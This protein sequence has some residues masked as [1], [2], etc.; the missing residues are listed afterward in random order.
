MT[1]VAWASGDGRAPAWKAFFDGP[2]LSSRRLML[3]PTELVRRQII[4]EV[5]QEREAVLNPQVKTFNRLES[6]LSAEL[7]PPPV[8]KW[9]KA[10]ELNVLAPELWGA[11]GLPGEPRPAGVIRLAA[12]L[13]DG[14]D[15]LRLAGLSWDE[16]AG[17]APRELT[18]A[19]AEAGRR[20]ERWLGEADDAASRRLKLLEALRSGRRFAAL[21]EVKEIWCHHSQRLS[22]FE[23]EFLKALAVRC[24]VDLRLAA[25]AWLMAENV[26]QNSGWMRLRLLRDLETCPADGL[27]LSWVDEPYRPETPDALRWASEN[28][29]G[30]PPEALRASPNQERPDDSEADDSDGPDESDSDEDGPDESDSDEDDSDEPDDSPEDDSDE[31]ASSESSG[32]DDEAEASEEEPADWLPRPLTKPPEIGSALTILECPTRYHEAE[33]I[34]RRLKALIVSGRPA[35]RLAVAV[36]DLAVFLPP[37]EDV[38]RRFGLHFSYRRGAVLADCG[39]VAALLDLLGLWDSNWEL[40]RALRILESPFFDFGLEAVPR[41]RLLEAGVTDERAGGGFA[42]NCGKATGETAELLKPALEVVKRLKFAGASL[43]RAKD[44]EAFRNVL[45]TVISDFGW[46]GPGLPELP[47]TPVA[48]HFAARAAV[49]LSAV[50]RLADTLNALFDA[51][52]SSPEA[53]PA[54]LPT[55]KLWL[56]QALAPERLEEE[57]DLGRGIRLVSYRDLHGTYWEA[58]FLMGLNERVFPAARAEAC[59]WPDS[60]VEAL[61][62]T[63]LGRRLWSSASEAYQ[64]GEEM[65]ALAMAQA[66]QVTLTFRAFDEDGRPALP[67]PAVE[68]LKSLWP[69]GELTAVKTGWPL[70][71]PAKLVCDPGELWMRLA[72][73]RS[74]GEPPKAFLEHGG[75]GR[76]AGRLWRQLERR[77]VRPRPLA[78]CPDDVLEAF[79][80]WLLS[81]EGVPLLG[82]R[83]LTD[84]AEC[85]RKFLFARLWG[86]KL[87]GEPVEGWSAL[88]QGQA[89]HTTLER[90]LAPLRDNGPLDLQP[91]RLKYIFWETVHRQQCRA[92]VGRLPQWEARTK[93]LESLLLGWLA[94]RPDVGRAKIE[95]L[96]WSFGEPRS[97]VPPLVLES[98]MGPFALRGRVDRLD[99]E[100]GRATVRDYK[101]TR[102]AY[103][104]AKWSPGDETPRPAWHYPLI[105]Y[106]LAA[107][108]AFKAPWRAV[109]E[110]VD[111]RGEGDL[112]ELQDG[113]EAD[114]AA[115]WEALASGST[116]PTEDGEVCGRCA[117]TALCPGEAS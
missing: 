43:A 80:S 50:P 3:A 26:V 102:S 53:P 39:P 5:L 103:Y 66:R 67:S 81:P 92:P 94:R 112:I 63:V 76:E 6:E 16:L 2:A 52:S 17:L 34:G 23:S 33:E 36:P 91:D 55:F 35:H 69:E 111:P 77:R 9:L 24:Q 47:D 99:L 58:L 57:D 45:Q 18:T 25:P 70:P 60:F 15:R 11:L 108:R 44:W 110:F 31:P 12:Q 101:L 7:G 59:W 46:P 98:A 107:Q 21:A 106:G 1:A 14:L 89:V 40:N 87:W 51:L 109:L 20:Y 37:L 42:D 65:L 113:G 79:M 54:S 49:D 105:M 32:G 116:A 62:A 85:P 28:L 114:L 74:G 19:M 61:S 117:F 82:V 115:L 41:Q 27:H 104:A 68:S 71:P 10:F 93:R 38:A 29:F 56:G 78:G 83:T 22:P 48:A 75:F 84:Y 30:P 64:Q 95:A 96:E 13:A 100:D 72:L 97:E 4:E 86:L 90:F 8:D 88:G 73:T